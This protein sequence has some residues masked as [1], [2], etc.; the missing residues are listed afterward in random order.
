MGNWSSEKVS[1]STPNLISSL[2]KS[3]M[4]FGD[5]GKCLRKKIVTI[6]ITK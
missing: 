4:V 5:P 3:G 1:G 6:T 2:I